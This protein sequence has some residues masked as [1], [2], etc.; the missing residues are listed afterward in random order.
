M[1]QPL[2]DCGWCLIFILHQQIIH[3]YKISHYIF[4][5]ENDI[6]ALHVVKCIYEA[7]PIMLIV[8]HCASGKLNERNAL[9][10]IL[11]LWQNSWGN[12]LN[13]GKGL[14]GL[15]VTEDWTYGWLFHYLGLLVEVCRWEERERGEGEV[16]KDIL[17]WSNSSQLLT[18][19]HLWRFHWFS[20][21]PRLGTKLQHEP[22]GPF[23]TQTA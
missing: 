22:W 13:K 9:V 18:G 21:G 11:S 2:W 7:K 5:N 8:Y 12:W 3:I 17:P 1:A 20:L 15:R 19:Y 4:L 16:F 14:L 10:S 6:S 23:M